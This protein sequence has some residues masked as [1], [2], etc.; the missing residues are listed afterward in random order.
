M[1]FEDAFSADHAVAW[2]EG[3]FSGPSAGVRPTTALSAEAWSAVGESF[4]EEVISVELADDASSPRRAR[5]VVQQVCQR[6]G[7]SAALVQRATV[8][9][10]EVVTNAVRH[11]SGN[12]WLK[13]MASPAGTRVEVTDESSVLPA[14]HPGRRRSITVEGGRGLWI[15]DAWAAGWGASARGGGK[16][17]WF[18]LHAR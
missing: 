10:S 17:V 12:P 9:T 1:S 2:P 6:A 3:P 4:S 15:L 7:L 18:E 5:S 11:G 16:V 8:L 14:V 13:V